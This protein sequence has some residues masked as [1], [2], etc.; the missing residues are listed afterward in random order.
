MTHIQRYLTSCRELAAF[1]AQNGWIDN[2]TLDYEILE[3]DDHH[4]LAFVQFEEILLEGGGRV[5][6]RIAHQG[7][8]RLALGRY[9]EVVHAE[10]V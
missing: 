4:V 7:R 6:G 10:L 9:G 1:C 8:L 5:A 3:Q 2:N